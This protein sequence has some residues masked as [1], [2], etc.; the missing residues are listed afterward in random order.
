MLVIHLYTQT[1]ARQHFAAS[2]TKTHFQLDVWTV[3][4]EG[5]REGGRKAGK[6]CARNL[7]VAAAAGPACTGLE[8][9]GPGRSNPGLAAGMTFFIYLLCLFASSVDAVS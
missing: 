7:P 6:K 9:A 4:V 1:R 8:E 5:G 3:V 2:E